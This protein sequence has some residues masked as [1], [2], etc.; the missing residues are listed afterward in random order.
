[1]YIKYDI[2][3]KLKFK[4]C[5]LL[6]TLSSDFCIFFSPLWNMIQWINCDT[7]NRNT[8]MNHYL[9]HVLT[10]YSCSPFES[11]VQSLHFAVLIFT[12]V[13]S[14]FTELWHSWSFIFLEKNIKHM[15]FFHFIL[16]N[17]TWENLPH[18]VSWI[19][20]SRFASLRTGIGEIKLAWARRCV[21]M[22]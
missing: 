5:S 7:C 19:K 17:E 8:S 13:L 9:L 18:S 3:T 20:Q 2:S 1:M 14:I 6:I 12:E 4:Q 16:H 10:W 15:I 11:I 21:W 22:R